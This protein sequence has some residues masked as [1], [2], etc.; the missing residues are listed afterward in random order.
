MTA[1]GATVGTVN[2]M[3]GPVVFGATM[4]AIGAVVA[5]I[6]IQGPWVAGDTAGRW[7]AGAPVN[8]DSRR[9]LMV[10]CAALAMAAFVSVAH[11]LR[12]VAVVAWV[13]LTVVLL[14]VIL[15]ARAALAS[16]AIS[17]GTGSA[18][19]AQARL[20]WGPWCALAGVGLAMVGL[21]AMI[22]RE[23]DDTPVPEPKRQRRKPAG[24]AKRAPAK[25]TPAKKAPAKKTAAKKTAARKTPAKRAPAR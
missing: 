15:D 10:G 16:P 14:F 22:R 1:G 23:L 7:T 6:G 9:W 17:P 19:V 20:G 12:W 2:P 21:M 25:Q 13:H 8:D 18:G 3:K 5:A 4:V 24:S 11:L